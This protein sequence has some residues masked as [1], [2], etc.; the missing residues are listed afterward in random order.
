MYMAPSSLFIVMASFWCIPCFKGASI[1]CLNYERKII[2]AQYNYCVSEHP[3]VFIYNTMFGRLHSISV[4]GWTPSIQLV[5]I[6]GHQHQHKTCIYIWFPQIG[7]SC[8]NWAQLSRSH[9]RMETIQS[10]KRVFEIKTGR[11]VMSRNTA[12][13]IYH[14]H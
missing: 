9:H 10:T 1:C 4:F 13:L 6:S 11:L 14:S 5:P 3:S 2:T 7:T 12:V 8:I